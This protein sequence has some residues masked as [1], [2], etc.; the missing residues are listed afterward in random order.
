MSFRLFPLLALATF[1][2][3]GCGDDGGDDTSRDDDTPTSTSSSGGSSSNRG[4]SI[5]ECVT[6]CT[7][8]ADTCGVACKDGDCRVGC[9]SDFS[10]CSKQCSEIR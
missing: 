10:N 2:P 9:D 4:Q 8:A 1:L 3:L 7:S 5:E 6:A